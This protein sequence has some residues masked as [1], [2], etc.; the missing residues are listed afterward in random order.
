LFG[1]G[2]GTGMGIWLLLGMLILAVVI[3]GI[4]LVMVW[5]MQKTVGGARGR[6]SALELLK[7]RYAR[8][9]ISREEFE[10]KKND[11]SP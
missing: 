6:D 5:F 4:V 7:M 2:M 8:G 3:P 11:I 10:E 1:N 9:E